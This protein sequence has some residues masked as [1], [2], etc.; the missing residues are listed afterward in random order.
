MHPDVNKSA[1]AHEQFVLLNEAYEY[2]IN[3]DSYESS[4]TQ[5]SSDSYQWTEQDWQEQQRENAKE[6]AREYARMRYAEFIKSDYYKEQKVV[7]TVTAHLGIL[8]SLLLFTVFP[9]VM[10]SVVGLQAIIG[11]FF[12]NL[13]LLPVHINAYRN[14]KILSGTDFLTSLTKLLYFRWFHIISMLIFNSIVLFTAVIHTLVTVSYVFSAYAIAIL[15]MLVLVKNPK[16]R[17]FL[18]FAVAPSIISLLFL[19]N[20]AFATNPIYEEFIIV[21]DPQT[22]NTSV[23]TLEKGQLD[24]YPGLRTFSDYFEIKDANRIEYTF[25]KGLFGLWVMTN[26]DIDGKKKLLK[27]FQ[28]LQSIN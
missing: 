1:D 18:S 8:L 4:S 11:L 14:L 24:E 22:R 12:I 27:S 2:L 20:F 28:S 19:I 6:R 5:S 9:I 23:I 3:V 17:N 10:F 15:A 21:S 26:Y 7:D 25:E 16:N 13:I